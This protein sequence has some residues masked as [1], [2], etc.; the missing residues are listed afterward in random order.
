M[1]CKTYCYRATARAFSLVEVMVVLVIVG[2]LA[3]LVAV[4]ARHYLTRGKQSAAK[5]ELSTFAT[6]LEEY[7]SIYGR[8]PGNDEGLM[9]LRQS[10]DRIPEPLITQDPID[11]WGRPYQYVSPASDSAYEIICLGADGREGGEGA[12]ADISSLDLKDR[13]EP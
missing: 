6:A 8:Y 13:Q 7:N 1:S 5:T 4:N 12:D 3:G 10:S 9:A 2:L 11:P